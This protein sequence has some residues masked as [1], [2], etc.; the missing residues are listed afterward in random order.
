MTDH[1]RFFPLLSTSRERA[2]AP[3]ASPTHLGY[4]D[5]SS[6]ISLRY[7]SLAL[8]T[9]S[10]DSWAILIRM[11]SAVLRESNVRELAWR[12]RFRKASIAAIK[13]RCRLQ[14]D[15]QSA[16]EGGCLDR[17]HARLEASGPAEG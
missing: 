10:A 1:P 16:I 5:E 4:S 6:G 14:H 17:G 13:V 12:K 8:D 9:G 2:L 15:A 11:V 7:R 3:D